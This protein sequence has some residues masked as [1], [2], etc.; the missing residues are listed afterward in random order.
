[1]C[2]RNE[3]TAVSYCSTTSPSIGAW[4]SLEVHARIGTSGLT[5]VWLDGVKLADL[6]KA[7]NLGSSAIG[8]V[9]LGNNQTGR[10][11]DVAFDDVILDTAPIGSAARPT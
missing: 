8:R 1:M 6:S 7:Q 11:Y 10:T 3:I 4:H 2:L 5:E 9:Q